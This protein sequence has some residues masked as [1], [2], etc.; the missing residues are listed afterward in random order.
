MGKLILGIIPE[1]VEKASKIEIPLF[2]GK[3]VTLDMHNDEA[4]I[5]D[6]L[7][8]ECAV[9]KNVHPVE[10]YD[11]LRADDKSVKSNVYSREEAKK[12]I[13]ENF[14]NLMNRYLKS[15]NKNVFSATDE[16]I[17]QILKQIEKSVNSNIRLLYYSLFKKFLILNCLKYYEKVK[18]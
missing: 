16:E 3:I 4:P 14:N 12:V 8:M 1:K 2:N 13:T 6:L 7:L 11:I 18:K 17:N 9:L 15:F 10:M 5:T